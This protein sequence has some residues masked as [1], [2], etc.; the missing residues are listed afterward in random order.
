MVKREREVQSREEEK[1]KLTQDK[2]RR[3]IM[4]M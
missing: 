1:E 3:G 4:I 2:E